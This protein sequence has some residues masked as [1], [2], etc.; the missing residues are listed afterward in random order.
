MYYV[1]G[2][3]GIHICSFKAAFVAAVVVI[4]FNFVFVFVFV[5]E[6]E[7]LCV[8]LVVLELTL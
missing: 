6:P 5:L 2:Y 1:T 3:I 8:A 4:V 7:L